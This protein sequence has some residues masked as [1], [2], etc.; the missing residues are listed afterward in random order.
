[1]HKSA[2]LL[3]SLI[4]DVPKDLAKIIVTYKEQMDLMERVKL[5]NGE[6][7]ET[8]REYMVDNDHFIVFGDESHIMRIRFC[9]LCPGTMLFVATPGEWTL[10]KCPKCR[11]ATTFTSFGRIDWV[12]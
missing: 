8:Y 6:L 11:R 7:L 3:S 12:L 1:M 4:E 10:Y 5:I 9:L 2:E